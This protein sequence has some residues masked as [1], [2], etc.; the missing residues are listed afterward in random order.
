MH[1]EGLLRAKM[2]VLCVKYYI[3][4]L[5]CITEFNPEANSVN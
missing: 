2:Q 3:I 1:Y 5:I 4:N